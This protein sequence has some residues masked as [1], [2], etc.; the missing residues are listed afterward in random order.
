MEAV[1]IKHG[2]CGAIKAE[3]KSGRSKLVYDKARRTI[4]VST[5]GWQL[6]ETALRDGTEIDIWI[7]GPGPRRIA[8]CRWAKPSHASW[9]DRYGDD[10]DLPAQWITRTGTALDSRNGVPTH[11]MPLPYPPE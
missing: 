5:T 1:E 2:D 11:W 3:R 10:S 6:I 9:G 7:S 8:N 4:A